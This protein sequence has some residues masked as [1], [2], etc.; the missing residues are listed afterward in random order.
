MFRHKPPLNLPIVIYSD[1]P[2]TSLDDWK[3]PSV[4]RI[5]VTS[6]LWS[7]DQL[8][9]QISHEL[10]HVMLDPR[11]NNGF[12]DT[13]CSA[14]SV[15]LLKE[16]AVEWGDD[17]INYEALYEREAILTLPPELRGSL[18]LKDWES[19]AAYLK[20][21]TDD[22]EPSPDPK[23]RMTELAAALLLLSKPVNWPDLVGIA[24][25]T[26]PPPEVDPSFLQ[27][28]ILPACLNRVKELAC[29]IEYHCPQ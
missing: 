6:P 19:V 16:L 20:S 7:S 12:V 3:N 29:R 1:R 22:L 25:C 9:F 28:P 4:I 14:L 10:G 23:Y 11:R 13:I 15:A 21:H 8:I 26:F 2:I 17:L 27:L 18:L 24:G 5:G